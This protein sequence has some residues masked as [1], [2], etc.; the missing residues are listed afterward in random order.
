VLLDVLSTIKGLKE[1][2]SAYLEKAEN[3]DLVKNVIKEN[4]E[5]ALMHGAFGAPTIIVTKEGSSEPEMF[6]GSDRFEHI[7]AYLD[8]PYLGYNPSSSKL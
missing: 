2:P 6:F 8:E 3:D 5:D 1:S 7:A 4:T